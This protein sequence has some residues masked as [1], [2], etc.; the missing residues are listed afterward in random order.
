[1]YVGT[2]YYSNLS[3]IG[4]AANMNLDGLRKGD[5]RGNPY[6][7]DENEGENCSMDQLRIF[8]G[9]GISVQTVKQI[10]R[11]SEAY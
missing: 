3:T 7:F 11:L 10:P 5:S 1:M 2:T 9:S 4:S 6:V 8:T